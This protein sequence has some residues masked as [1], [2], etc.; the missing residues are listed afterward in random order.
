MDI[1]PIFTSVKTTLDLL[2]GLESNAVLNERV[3]LL[4]DQIEILRYAHE[5]AQKELSEYKEKCAALENE[6]ASY[7]QAE[8]FIFEHGAAFKKTSS[9]YIEAVYC[10]NCLTV[11]GGSFSTFPFQCGKCKWRS[12]FKVS[13]FKGIFKSLP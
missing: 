13:E 12:M 8:Q 10:P 3:A 4:K 5:T 1:S 2:S 11:A 9:G 6:I 7:R